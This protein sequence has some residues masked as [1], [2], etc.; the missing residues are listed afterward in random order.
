MKTLALCVLAAQP[1]LRR[2]VA[3]V[4]DALHGPPDPSPP[5]PS[6]ALYA[7]LLDQARR[8]LARQ[9]RPV[10]L[11]VFFFDSLQDWRQALQDPAH[12]LRHC[13]QELFV[14]QSPDADQ[15]LQLPAQLRAF[16]HQAGQPLRCSPHSFLLYLQAADDDL[17]EQPSA[18]WPAASTGGLHLRLAH[19]EAA[20]RRADLLRVLLDH[21]DHAHHN[22]LLARSVDAAE[23]PPA[24]ARALHAFMQQRWPGRWDFH[25]YT[26]S[27]IAASSRACA[28]W[29]GPTDARSWAAS[30]SMAWPARPWPAGSC[31]G[32]PS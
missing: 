2:D 24:L 12:G 1:W 28:S 29:A 11:S 4:V 16:A 5:E 17:H 22:R 13:S 31:S 6:Q 32:V 10:A 8:Y 19:P 3:M 26:G 9:A 7:G 18:L 20:M 15:A 21:L 25:G 27:V 30:T 14:L 23:R